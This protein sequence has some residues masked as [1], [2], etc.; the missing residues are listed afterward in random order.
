MF[1]KIKKIGKGWTYFWLVQLVYFICFLIG[2]FLL[3]PFTVL[4]QW[5]TRQS[6]QY[7]RQ[8]LCWKLE[9]LN[10]IWGNEEDGIDGAQ[11]YKDRIPSIRWRTYL[12]SAWRNSANNLRF[13]FNWKATGPF[14]RF[15]W[16]NWY[17]QAG[18]YKDNGWPVLSAGHI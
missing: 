4:K 7:D 2:I 1:N 16:R 11:F 8:I 12:W 5:K 14:Y 10:Y 17:F 3:I 13:V 6:K 15:E 9:W 18:F